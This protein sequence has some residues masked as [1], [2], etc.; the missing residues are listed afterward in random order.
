MGN[1][2]LHIRA[3]FHE[4]QPININITEFTRIS[5]KACGIPPMDQYIEFQVT[6]IIMTTLAVVF[7]ILRVTCKIL[8]PTLWGIDDT[9]ISIS[10][11]RTIY[12]TRQEFS[13][14]VSRPY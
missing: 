10:V 1:K 6:G 3:A 5:K 12:F 13:L 9:L 11:V 14:I 4:L 7:Y 2:R 8:G